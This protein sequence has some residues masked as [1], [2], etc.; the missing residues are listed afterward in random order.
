M[1][2]IRRAVR[3]SA[4]NLARHDLATFLEEH[5]D[6]LRLIFH[7]EIQKLDDR[8]P[9]ED[10]FIDINMVGMGDM[11]LTAAL[12][13]IRRFLLEAPDNPPGPVVRSTARPAGEV[14]PVENVPFWK[15]KSRQR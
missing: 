8:I 11:I 5:E 1:M 12:H 15:R 3:E 4:F 14:K 7:E 9:E 2:P 13:A 6:R 10:F